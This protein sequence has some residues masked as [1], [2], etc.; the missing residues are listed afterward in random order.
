MADDLANQWGRHLCN[1]VKS[2][3]REDRNKVRDSRRD[4]YK[5]LK[6]SLARMCKDEYEVAKVTVCGSDANLWAITEATIHVDS[7]SCEY[8]IA[9]GSYVSGDM[10]PFQLLSSSFFCVQSEVCHITEPVNAS[11]PAKAKTIALPYYIPGTSKLST[12]A[13][14][15]ML[16]DFEKE[17]LTELHMRCLLG[18]LRGKP[19]LVLFLELIL[20]GNGAVLSDWMLKNLGVL[21]KHHG[22]SIIVDEILTGAR[23]GPDLIVTLSTPTEFQASVSHVTLGKFLGLGI[24]LRNINYKTS[25]YLEQH[26]CQFRGASTVLQT[27]DALVICNIVKRRI[28][29]IPKRRNTVLRKFKV[30]EEIAWGRGLIVFIP[31]R[32]S[33]SS[34]G[35]KNRYLP[36][37]AATKLDAIKTNT[38]KSSGKDIVCLELRKCEKL[39]LQNS[40]KTGVPVERALCEVLAEADRGSYWGKMELK[41]TVERKMVGEIHE[42]H[43][44][45]FFSKQAEI[46][47]FLKNKMRGRKRE[48]KL[49]LNDI[50]KQPELID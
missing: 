40:K 33:D 38:K 3:I 15:K 7:V 48:R 35:L 5:E 22:F 41:S 28:Q 44:V 49:I 37:L 11:A 43:D 30:N 39:W 10:G 24:V 50:C 18:T 32:R 45:S 25:T 21:A 23:V 16:A 14:K 17:C 26:P 19:V 9:N 8:L 1:L 20:A 12:K 2:D 36:L 46:C 31:K 42:K 6:K 27:E 47:N 29:S 13:G 34:P 4:T